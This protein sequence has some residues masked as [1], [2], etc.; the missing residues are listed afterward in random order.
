[1]E[2]I[3]TEECKKFR[4]VAKDL[5]FTIFPNNK[6]AELQCDK[7]VDTMLNMQSVAIDD[8]YRDM[9]KWSDLCKYCKF[10][11]AKPENGTYEEKADLYLKNKTKLALLAWGTIVALVLVIGTILNN[12]FAQMQKDIKYIREEIIPVVK[13]HSEKL[14]MLMR[15]HM[16]GGG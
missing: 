16:K 11:E 3:A 14:D 15:L 12:Q 9:K 13:D 10:N 4:N 8:I 6:K 2:F 5:V 7:L 1:M